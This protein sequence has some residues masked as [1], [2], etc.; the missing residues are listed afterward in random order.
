MASPGIRR[1]ESTQA[2]PVGRLAT[3]W[4]PT[5]RRDIDV[6]FS[7]PVHFTHHVL[8]SENP[9]L[10][11]TVAHGGPGP[12]D[13]LAAVDAGVLA[14]KPDLIWRL[15]SYCH[16][17]PE[18]LSLV[19]EPLIF[20]GGETAKDGTAHVDALHAAIDA[21]GICRHSYVLAIGGGALLDMVGFA[22][23]TAHRGIRLV[24]VPTTVLAQNDSAIGVKTAV[25]RNG[26]KNFVGTFAAPWAV[27]NDSSFLQT[28]SDR[29]WRAG[30]IEA[31]KVGL[32]RDADFVAWLHEKAPAL[33]SRDV[34]AMERLVHRCAELHLDHIAG[35]GDPFESGSSRPLDFGHWAGHKLEELSGYQLRHGEAV[36]VGIALDAT[37]SYVTGMLD[38]LDWRRVLRVIRALGLPLAV[39]ELNDPDAVL[40]GLEEFREH[41]GGRLTITLLA[42]IGDSREVHDMDTA[43]V[44]EAIGRLQ[45]QA[46]T[47]TLVVG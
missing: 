34:A 6:R 33:L 22:A 17:Y 4:P 5:L 43:Q 8:G 20:P 21:H 10:A 39:P 13:V 1:V 23:S 16:R 44:V 46:A 32:L 45:A 42:G 14:V 47:A 28:L 9:L 29:D 37:Y 15:R 35:A 41:L 25:N 38:E 30:T 2:P 7:Y 31:L 24:R 19:G 40:E 18:A 27:L 36:A 12:H 3:S 26:K 11:E